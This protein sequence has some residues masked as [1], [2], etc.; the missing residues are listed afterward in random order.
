[1]SDLEGLTRRLIK[2]GYPKERIVKRLIQEYLDFKDNIDESTARNYANA[3]FD[4]CI[5]S[6][7]NSITDVFTKDLLDFH[8]ANVTVGK[9]G[10]G[11]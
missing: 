11:C 1:M 7:I 9:Q 5:K 4:E 3:I 6:D 10:V 2:K 8:R